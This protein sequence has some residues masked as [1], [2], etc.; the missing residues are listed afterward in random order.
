MKIEHFP[1]KNKPMTNVLIQVLMFVAWLVALVIQPS[2]VIAI[3]GLVVLFFISRS[4][5]RD[6]IKEWKAPPKHERDDT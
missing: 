2:G 5:A 4:I 6:L 1:I 3:T